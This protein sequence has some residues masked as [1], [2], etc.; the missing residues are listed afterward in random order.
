MTLSCVPQYGRMSTGLIGLPC[1]SRTGFRAKPPVPRRSFYS[2]SIVCVSS[3]I[4]QALLI[5]TNRCFCFV[6][7]V[8]RPGPDN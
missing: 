4:C 3:N 6:Q 1:S 5:V 2:A 8:S 7:F